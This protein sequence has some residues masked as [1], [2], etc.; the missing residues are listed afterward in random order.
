MAKIVS[1]IMISN[2]LK[3]GVKEV[4]AAESTN[5]TNIYIYIFLNESKIHKNFV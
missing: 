2:G 1:K 4:N 3:K 5:V